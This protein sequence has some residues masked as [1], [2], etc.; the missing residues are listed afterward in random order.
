MS[1]KKPAIYLDHAAATPI[2]DR[3][4][5][6]M[7]PYFSDKFYNPSAT[8]DTARKVRQDLEK[9][10][11]QVAHWLGAKANEIIFTAGGSEANNLAIHGIMREF[12]KGNIVV[13]A[14]EHDSILEPAARYDRRLVKVHPDGRLDLNDLAK[15]IDDRTVMVSIVYASNEIGTVQPLRDIA[16]IIDQKKRDRISQIPN[17]KSQNL[18]L[19]FHSDACQAG[20]YLDLHVNRLGIDLLTLNGGKI[21][22][23][24]QSGALYI[25]AGVELQPLIDGGGQER[26]LRSGTEN[27]AGSIGLAMAI[28]LAQSARQA[29]AK[30]LRDLQTHFFKILSEKIPIA[31]IN[32]S[33][34]YR[35]PNNLHITFPGKDNERL[36]VQLDEA[37]IQAAAGSACSALSD[38]PSHVLSAVGLSDD[39]A[40]ASLRLTTGRSTTEADVRRVVDVLS[41]L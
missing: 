29:E 7:R 6:A 31:V 17:P 20:N 24:K 34:K 1:T 38:T 18:P 25:K 39:Q 14:M 11:A 23:P 12:P 5:A 4:L 19:Y 26:G 32:G 41:R 27:V 13:S 3:V 21:Y 30:R 37:G 10:R 40:R 16:K 35:L 2:D 33:I 28:D 15:K 9:A 36:L 22:G 8:Y